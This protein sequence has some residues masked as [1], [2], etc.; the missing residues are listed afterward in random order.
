[1]PTYKRIS[2]YLPIT[3]RNGNTVKRFAKH[4]VQCQELVSGEHML[5]VAVHLQERLIIAAEAT[6]PRCEARFPIACVI[7]DDK[8]VH[9]VIVPM[10]ILRWWLSTVTPVPATDQ[11]PIEPVDKTWDFQALNQSALEPVSLPSESLECSS[12]IIGQY[13]NRPIFAWVRDD[14]QP[15]RFSHILGEHQKKILKSDEILVDR[16]LVYQRDPPGNLPL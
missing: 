8:H 4:C 6:C 12:E 10:R 14:Q 13:Q 3:F 2:H 7:T 11:R 9:R 16:Y 5:G 15:Y 1:M